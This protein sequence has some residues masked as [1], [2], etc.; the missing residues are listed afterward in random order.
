[1]II[2]AD[3]I[4]TRLDRIP[5][6][7]GAVVVRNGRVHAVGK[8]AAITRKYPGHHIVRL[9]RAVVMPGLVNVHT[10]LELPPL[11]DDIRAQNYTD[12]VLNLLKL[13]KRLTR[14]DYSSAAQGN[15]ASLIRSGTTTVAEISTHGVSPLA[16]RKSGLRSVVYHEII[17]MR[18]DI[19]SLSFPRCGPAS[20]L[21][22]YGLSPHS[23]HTVSEPALRA[24]HRFSSRRHLRL[25]MHVA[26]TREE[27]L[28]LQRRKNGLERLYAAAGW[29][30][31]RAP[32]AR[33]SFAH[34]HRLGVLGPSFLAVHA[35]HVDDQDIALI[36]RS[37][38]GIAHCPRSNHEIGTG[39]MPLRKFLDARI[40][41]GLGTDSL[42]SSP[43][44]DLWDEM[45]YALRTHRRSGV[46]PQDIFHMA[47]LG[48]ARALDMDEEIGSLEPGKNADLIA[49]PLPLK[50]TGDAYSDLLRETKTCILTMV[51]GRILHQRQQ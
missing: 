32:V 17:F 15:I 40:S 2:Q 23:P 50:D 25:C 29:D 46:T 16:L 31:N 21:V 3:R 9:E 28:L 22:R 36:K 44:L 35:V 19:S 5:L 4:I 14:H 10:H 12:W 51:N 7:A 26:E 8:A 42:A 1:M 33:S 18:E 20:R 13:K 24:I 45:R 27:T 11:L 30:M 47:T 38:A 6:I 48:G 41:V 37:G 34:L 49:V 39:T 43:S